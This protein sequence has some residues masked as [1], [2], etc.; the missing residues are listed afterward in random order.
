MKSAAFCTMIHGRKSYHQSGNQTVRSLLRYARF[1]IYVATDKPKRLP[2]SRHRRCRLH[3][4]EPFPAGISRGQ[5][6]LAKF[7]ALRWAIEHGCEDVVIYV[8]AD[9]LLARPLTMGM[10]RRA[11]G[12]RNMAMVEQ[13][14]V[15]GSGMTRADFL[16]HYQDH[17]LDFL[18]QG[19]AP[20]PMADFRYYNSGIVLARRQEW[21]EFLDWAVN[22]LERLPE[23]HSV[24]EHMIADQDYF[25]F[26]T[27]NQRPGTCADLPWYWNHCEHWDQD[28][29]RPGVLFAHFSN[30]CLGPG[31][32]TPARME[33]LLRP[34]SAL[35]HWWAA[36]RGTVFKPG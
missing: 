24:G 1:P 35:R 14:T 16:R 7:Q 18:A 23:H 12:D 25:Q 27:N 3:R 31:G 2:A 20:P 6:F 8:D 21:M 22:L 34:G 28:F 26:W 15:T 19:E 30:F 17:S 33:P 32:E 29:C 4:I 36:W 5:R 9:A 11:M 10:V 13:T